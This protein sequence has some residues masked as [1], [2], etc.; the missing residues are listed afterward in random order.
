[1]GA[2]SVTV[3]LANDGRSDTPARAQ[4]LGDN[5]RRGLPMR[6]RDRLGGGGR[7]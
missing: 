3:N 6:D 7:A 4:R 5:F 1:M 2:D